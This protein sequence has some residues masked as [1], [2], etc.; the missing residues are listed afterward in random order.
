MDTVY[1][2]NPNT[3]LFKSVVDTFTVRI[4]TWINVV[5]KESYRKLS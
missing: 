3:E 1:A 5:D 4:Y 2:Y